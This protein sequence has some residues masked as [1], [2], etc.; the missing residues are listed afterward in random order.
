MF[1]IEE[2]AVTV[3]FLNKTMGT[4]E[5]P[6]LIPT[7]LDALQQPTNPHQR[8]TTPFSDRMETELGPPGDAAAARC[9]PKACR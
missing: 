5:E 9:L 3:A 4:H 7:E 1:C 2:I 6:A 8:I